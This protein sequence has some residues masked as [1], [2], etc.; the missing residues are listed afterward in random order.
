MYAC[1][2]A[3]SFIDIA[4]SSGTEGCMKQVL[5]LSAQRRAILADCD[6]NSPCIV[7]RM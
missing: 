6:G 2:H 7:A 3:G 1:F 4:I 5:I